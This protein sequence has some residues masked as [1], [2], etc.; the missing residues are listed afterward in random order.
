MRRTG[1]FAMTR[2]QFRTSLKSYIRQS[3]R[4]TFLF[5][6]PIIAIGI[7]I[8]MQPGS[9][10]M[11]A[12]KRI[13]VLGFDGLDY[14][15]VNQYISEGKLPNLSRLKE[16]GILSSL[17][18]SIPPESPVAW[19]TF[20]TGT[21]PGKT[22]IFDF[23]RRNPD[24]YFPELNMTDVVSPV[25]FAFNTIPIKPPVLRNCRNGRSFW[26]YASDAG[27]P[28]KGIMMPMNM[29]PDIAP[30]SQVLSGLGVPDMRRTMG[31]YIY[32]V[33][34]LDLAKQRT[35][36]TGGTEMGGRVVEVEKEGNQITTFL[37]GPY[38]PLKPGTGEELKAPVTM[39]VDAAAGTIDYQIVNKTPFRF[40]VFFGGTVLGLITCL[41]LWFI[42]AVFGKNS[43]RGLLIGLVAFM[44]IL[45]LLWVTTMP[46][47]QATNIHLAENEWSDWIPVKYLV[48]PWLGVEGFFRLYLIEA[49]PEFQ[50]YATPVNID[51]R[52]TATNLSF[53]GNYAKSLLD[54]YGDFKTYGWDSETWALNENVITESVYMD[55]LLANWDQKANMVVDEM[56]KDNWT[57]FATV[58]QGTDHVQ[59]MFWRMIDP[60]HPMYDPALAQLFGDSIL[61]VYERA[62]TLVGRV[63][64]EV[65]DDD[66]V[67]LV[68]SD[69]G[70]NP[71]RKA[72]NVN[73]WLVDNGYLAELAGS[74][75]EESSVYELFSP[76][77][78]FF[79]WVDWSK[80]RAYAL[81]L[82]QIYI[83]LE[84][85]E[86]N[87]IV[88]E[89]E[90]SA[91][92]DEIIAG[93]KEIT[94]SATGEKILVNVY[95][96]DQIY[97]GDSMKYA[98]DIV[99]GF[100]PGYRVSWQTTLGVEADRLI[101]PN[102]HKW[103]GDHCSF[104]R[105]V[106]R[107]VLFSTVPITVDDPSLI[108][109]AP[110]ILSLVGVEKPS[111][112]DGRVIFPGQ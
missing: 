111:R 22:G 34:D 93:L 19:S 52:G 47:T 4:W 8:P 75:S 53:P 42:Y 97:Q 39:S 104:D 48:T 31:T 103:S 13:V 30:G 106:T 102:N 40:F 18:S 26:G 112:C 70:F 15:L 60:Q 92:I 35:G 12:G 37:P 14:D 56:K 55:D 79:Q 105:T 94:D 69:H 64:D 78:E 17:M 100:A 108:D 1:I 23:L 76:A 10:A 49:G 71:F 36:S 82:G 85:R 20:V 25:Q 33:D 7:L 29:P 57:I 2:K 80:S 81:G 110:S 44:V 65:L 46:R 59:H 41:L 91:L 54:T 109:L 101:E 32:Y 62:D 88:T 58:F 84:G 86:K 98:P 66:D 24:T 5:L 28:S 63:M 16:R 107:G 90:R 95:R 67:L 74:T 72:V 83:N 61:T 87:G 3:L 38:D 96:A 6:A 27:I 9:A 51:P 11:A 68:M 21:N 89:N 77:S 43:M 99:L 45:V 50:L 73:R